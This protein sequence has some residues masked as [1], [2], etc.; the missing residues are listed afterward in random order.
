MGDPSQTPLASLD[1]AISHEFA[2][3]EEWDRLEQDPIAR[4]VFLA[5]GAGHLRG[6]DFYEDAFRFS[7]HVRA[8]KKPCQHCGKAP[9]L[10]T[11]Q[12]LLDALRAAC[13]DPA[14]KNPWPPQPRYGRFP[15]PA[16]ATETVKREEIGREL[17]L[18]ELLAMVKCGLAEMVD[19]GEPKPKTNAPKHIK[20][21]IQPAPPEP[22]PVGTYEI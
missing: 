17:R 19:D 3:T 10:E 14:M 15:H 7:E 11:A 21:H 4:D 12:D 6:P 5:I 18:R 9:S 16:P 13:D 8:T 1:I 2:W 20:Y 22:E